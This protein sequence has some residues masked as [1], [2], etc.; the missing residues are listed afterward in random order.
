MGINTKGFSASNTVKLFYFFKP[1]TRH[2][3][4]ASVNH[5]P[6]IVINVPAVVN[7]KFILVIHVPV[8]VYIVLTYVYI[9]PV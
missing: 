9:L 6:I 5:K 1:G 8:S 3:V 2:H 7:Y 4:S